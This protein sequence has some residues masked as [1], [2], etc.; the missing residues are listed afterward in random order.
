LPSGYF[1]PNC[2]SA[3]AFANFHD[4]ETLF[5]TFAHLWQK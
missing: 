2:R 1:K 5:F 3:Y 4:P